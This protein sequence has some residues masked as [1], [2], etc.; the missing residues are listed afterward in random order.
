MGRG[1]KLPVGLLVLRS[2]KGVVLRHETGREVRMMMKRKKNDGGDEFGYFGISGV[3]VKELRG[4]FIG[5]I[6]ILGG[7]KEAPSFSKG[8]AD[9]LDQE[10]AAVDWLKLKNELTEAAEADEIGSCLMHYQQMISDFEAEQIRL[11]NE[12]S[13]LATAGGDP[14]KIKKENNEKL[15]KMSK[16][17]VANRESEVEREKI[18]KLVERLKEIQRTKQLT[19]NAL[20]AIETV[21]EDSV[22][23]DAEK[24]VEINTFLENFAAIEPPVRNAFHMGS[25]FDEKCWSVHESTPAGEDWCLVIEDV[26]KIN[27]GNIESQSQS[28]IEITRDLYTLPDLTMPL[29]ILEP[30]PEKGKK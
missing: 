30:T 16:E 21:P 19:H 4:V 29:L 24:K 15:S 22:W 6:I 14:K 23:G 10:S 18:L 8:L 11:E 1:S 17:D 2:E 13:L 5:G 26:L 27:Q 25:V 12:A 7:L 28:N 9:C 3:P 20:K